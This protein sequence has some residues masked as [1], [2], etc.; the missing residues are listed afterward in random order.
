V[1]QDERQHVGEESAEQDVEKDRR[2]PPV[3]RRDRRDDEEDRALD[4]D[5]REGDEDVVEPRR[6]MVDDPALE[7][8]VD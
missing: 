2:P 6:P 8:G 4:A 7:P 5:L 3:E 1:A